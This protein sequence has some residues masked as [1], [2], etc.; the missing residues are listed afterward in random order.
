MNPA[1]PVGGDDGVADAEQRDAVA[2]LQIA[3]VRRARPRHPAGRA[4]L[5]EQNADGRMTHPWR[6]RMH[7]T[8]T[9]GHDTE[10]VD[11]RQE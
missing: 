7:A 11:G 3:G 4:Q 9:L 10:I 1:V 5:A 8:R 6:T 2:L